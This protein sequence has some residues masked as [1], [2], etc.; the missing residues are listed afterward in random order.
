MRIVVLGEYF[1]PRMGS[2][3]RIYELMRRLV[4]K[5]EIIFL[6]VPSF[7]ELYGML[8]KSKTPN[9]PATHTHI[10]EGIIAHRIEIPKIMKKLWSKSLELAYIFNMVLLFPRVIRKLI[11]INPEIIILNY[12]SI[13]TGLLGFFSAKFLRRP[14]VVDFNDLIAQY[15]IHLLNLKKSGLVGRIIVFIQDFIVK[16]SSVVIT[17]TNFIKRYAVDLGVKDE[18]IF[19][20]PNGADLRVFDSKIKSN[21]RSRLD[22]NDKK[23]CLYFGRLD[24]WAGIH[25]LAELCHLFEQKRPDVKFLIVGGGTKWIEFPRNAVT[26]KEIPH[27]N[28]PNVISM[29]DVVLIPFPENEVSHAASPLKLFEAMAM[30]KP[31]VGSRV[32]GIEEVIQSGYNGLLADPNNLKDWVGAINTILDSESLCMKISQKARESIKKYDWT[33][34][35]SQFENVLLKTKKC[36]S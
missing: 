21:Y 31:V 28:I 7:R 24:D 13:Y 15:T 34:L 35:A 6:L 14:C 36:N 29:A 25:I 8:L 3:R 32:S 26:I 9:C 16:N 11:A 20:V 30:A 4:G 12:P 27:H 2:D 18:N 23:V 5:H 33:I 1:P 17:P 10:Y 22:L 19:V